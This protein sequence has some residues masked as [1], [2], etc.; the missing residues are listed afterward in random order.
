MLFANKI[1]DAIDTIIEMR[2]IL[3]AMVCMPF[4]SMPFLAV[5]QHIISLDFAEFIVEASLS[6][7]ILSLILERDNVNK[8]TGNK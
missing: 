7:F 1:R 5:D 6:I 4:A 3:I 2:Y 8:I